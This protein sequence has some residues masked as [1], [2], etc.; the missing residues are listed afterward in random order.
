MK[1]VKKVRWD[2]IIARLANNQVKQEASK[3][4]NRPDEPS[5]VKAK[6]TAMPQKRESEEEFQAFLHDMLNRDG[7][8][9][10]YQNPD[11]WRTYPLKKGTDANS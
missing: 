9:V 10:K 6:W 1:R 7:P 8:T 3:M 11:R 2:P 4:P 5:R